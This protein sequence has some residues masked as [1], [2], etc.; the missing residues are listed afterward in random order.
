MRASAT[1]ERNTIIMNNIGGL[2]CAPE[3]GFLRFAI[4]IGLCISPAL[5]VIGT[6]VVTRRISSLAGASTHA[7]LGGFGLAL[8]LQRV[9]ML[10]WF[11]PTVGA[12]IGAVTAAIV[13]GI[14]SIYAK[15]REDTVIGAV[16]AIGMSIGL[17]FLDRTPGY[18]DWQ[19]YLFGSILLL[20]EKDL[21]LTLVLDAVVLIP[22]IIF[23]P[24]LLAVVFDDTFARLRGIK[25]TT[26]YL[27]LLVLTAL[28]IVLLINLVGIMLVIALLTLPAAAAGC[29]TS[30]LK[31][32]MIAAA[33]FNAFFI[34]I[35]LLLSCL[36]AL[37]SGPTIVVLAG[38]VYVLS[39]I[40]KKN[41][42]K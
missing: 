4:L 14:V 39:T 16:W 40:W 28:T 3:W 7:A 30:H 1:A 11:T 33:V 13:V 25:V 23:F 22:T 5:G 24:A 2:F 34:C 38:A 26:I 10:S 42:S 18:V 15:E 20:T 29:F 37:P 27:G 12:V 32:T 21:L 8:F 31:S 17:L 9:C 35:G 36:F 6:M 19:G 41:H